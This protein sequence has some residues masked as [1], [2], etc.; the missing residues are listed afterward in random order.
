MI[1]ILTELGLIHIIRTFNPFNNH[2]RGHFAIHFLFMV[3]I[4]FIPDEFFRRI[5]TLSEMG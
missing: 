2:I 3:S 4:D 1:S 5:G